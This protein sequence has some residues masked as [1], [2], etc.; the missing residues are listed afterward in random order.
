MKD[1]GWREKSSGS[2]MMDSNV[3]AK[4]V[5]MGCFSLYLAS[6]GGKC[7]KYG[8]RTIILG[9]VVIQYHISLLH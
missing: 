7:K 9:L 6:N 5:L 1:G 4:H 3:D 8:L 2:L